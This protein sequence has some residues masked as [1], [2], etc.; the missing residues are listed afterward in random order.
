MKPALFSPLNNM[1]LHQK[2]S[3]VPR[4]DIFIS[5]ARANAEQVRPSWLSCADKGYRVF[6]D[7]KE[8]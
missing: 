7:Q 3:T 6:F 4:Y 1:E 8:Y 2:V 5:Y